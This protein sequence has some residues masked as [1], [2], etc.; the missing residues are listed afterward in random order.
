MVEIVTVNTFIFKHS[1]QQK[2]KSNN[3]LEIFD[4]FS[5]CLTTERFW[6]DVKKTT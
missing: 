1:F 3:N 4:L 2:S 5:K 6:D